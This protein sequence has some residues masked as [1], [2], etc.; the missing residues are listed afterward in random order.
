[1]YI[2]NSIIHIPET[3][4][5]DRKYNKAVPPLRKQMENEKK[6]RL[7][8]LNNEGSYRILAEAL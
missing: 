4:R 3:R 7:D 6:N 5:V 8:T 2:S 1:M